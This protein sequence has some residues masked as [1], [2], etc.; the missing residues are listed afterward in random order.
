[1]TWRSLADGGRRSDP[2]RVRF[3]ADFLPRLERLVAVLAAA[4]ERDEGGA[5]GRGLGGGDEFVGHRAYRLGED[6]RDFDW[7]LYARLGRPFVRVRRREAGERWCVLLDTSASMGVGQ[8]GKLQ[9]A[10]EIA[11]GIAFLGLRA[12]ASTTLLDAS[13]AAL[14][15]RKRTDLAAWFA[16]LET[17]VADGTK[18]VRELLADRRVDAASRLFVVG[19]LLDCEP[20]D[21]LPRAQRGRTLHAVRVLAP[22]ELAPRLADGVEWIDPENDERLDVRVGAEVL[23]AYARALT[24]RLEA[25]NTS[26]ARRGQRHSTWSS[27]TPFEDVVRAVL[28]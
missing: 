25:W 28:A 23:E 8:P 13:G 6:L 14:S 18:G 11:S 26:F 5:R 19:D 20:S 16:F 27:A 1:M 7:E 9:A 2:R 21:V 22:H 10:A 24:A 15:L 17:R 4:R 3:A 12:G